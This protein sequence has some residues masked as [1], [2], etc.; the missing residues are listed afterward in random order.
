VTLTALCNHV[1]VDGSAEVAQ[2]Y[3]DR[4]SI[5][6]AQSALQFELPDSLLFA[7]IKN[8]NVNLVR[9]LAPFTAEEAVTAALESAVLGGDR[10]IVTALLEYGADPNRLSHGC[11]FRLTET[12]LQLF[13]LILRAPRPLRHEN[14]GNLCMAVIQHGDS[15][16]LNILLRSILDYQIFRD[17]TVPWNRDSLLAAA[18]S[19]PDKAAFFAITAATCSWPLR[20]NRLF[21]Q[22]LE[23]P[24]LDR[25][26]A[27]DMLEVLL[28]LI[29]SMTPT[30]Q[31]DPEMQLTL[32]HCIQQQE[33]DIL[34]L[35]VSYGVQ[36]SAEPLLL[37]CQNQDV[38]ILD[39]LLTGHIRGADQVVARISHL[40][41]YGQRDMRQRILRRLLADG[42]DG[43]WK[44]SEL[45]KAAAEGQAQWV[46]ALL[47]GNA[48]VDYHNG[49]ALLEAVSL[50]HIP[51]VQKLLSR[52]VCVGSLQAAFPSVRQLETL[53]R[54]LLTKLF[55]NQGLTGQ[56]LDE[57]LNGE[58]CNYSYHRDPDLVDMLLGAGGHC[59]DVSLTVAFE[60]RDASIFD[61]IHLSKTILHESALQWFRG[62]HRVLFR[63]IQE[64][65]EHAAVSSACLK[66]LLSK[67]DPMEGLCDTHDGTR[68]LECFHQFLERGAEDIELLSACF[69]WAQHVDSLI[70]TELVLTTACFCDLDRLQL[71]VKSKPLSSPAPPQSSSFSR[72][73]VVR[74]QPPERLNQFSAAHMPP[75]HQETLE[76]SDA[77]TAEALKVVFRQCLRDT[78]ES[79]LAT[80]LLKRHLEQ[81]T[82][83]IPRGEPWPMLAV[84]YLLSQ[85]IEVTLP[86]YNECLR[87]AITSQ[88]WLVLESMLDRQLPRD[89]LSSFLLV[90]TSSLTPAALQVLLESQAMSCMKDE[91]FSD[92]VQRAFNQACLAQDQK[93]AVL[94]CT[95]SRS[96][97]SITDVLTSLQQAIDELELEYIS[98]LL[99]ATSSSSDEL[100]VLW[101]HVTQQ[102][103][104]EFLA[105]LEILLKAGA[106]GSSVAATLL[107]AIG[108]NDE[109]LVN[110]ILAQWLAPRF[111]QHREEFDYQNC[112]P[113]WKLLN[114]VPETE[115]FTVL[116]QSL[117][118]AVRL[119]QPKICK[120]LCAA[121]APLVYQRQ[122]LIELAVVL[123][124]HKALKELIRHSTTCPEMHDAVNF[125][126][127][128][129]V[130]NNRPTWI[131]GLVELGGSVA[132][133]GLEPLKAAASLDETE[134]L[135]VLLPYNQTLDGLQA[136]H[137]ILGMRLAQPEAD[138][139]NLCAMFE[140]VH[141]AGSDCVES[142]S[143]A[144]LSLSGVRL[145][146]ADHVK[147]LIGC[148]AS[149][150]YKNGECMRQTWRHGN[151]QL[152]PLLLAQ[153]TQT[154]VV[155]GL[156]SQA[157]ED[158]LREGENVFN[159]P[160]EGALV[161]FGALLKREASQESR[162]LSLDAIARRCPIGDDCRS[163]AGGAEIVELLLENGARFIDGA[164]SPLFQVCR[165]RNKPKIQ[166]LVLKSNP[167]MRSRFSALYHLF[168]NQD[169]SAFAQSNILMVDDS[170]DQACLYN[171][172]FPASE[173][174]CIELE[175][176]DIISLL[177][178]M[179]N[180]RRRGV[181]T[182][183]MFSFFF[184]RG[185]L[186]LLAPRICGDDDRNEVEQMLVAAIM[187][188][189]RT[190]LE[191]DRAEQRIEFLLRVLQID[192]LNAAGVWSDTTGFALKEEA[193]NRL[194]ILSLQH[195]RFSLVGT[196][197]DSGADP[198][199]TDED[200][201][202]AL[203]VATVANSLD[204]M[205]IL[206]EKG[207]RENDGSLHIATC[208]QHH[209]AMHRLLEA[210]HSPSHCSPLFLDGTPLEAFL[211]CGHPGMN[212]DLFGVTLAVLLCDA[213]L[214]SDFWTREPSP[215]S[216][217]LVGSTPYE[218]FS[219]LLDLLPTKV[220]EL[221]LVRQDRFMLSIL[222]LVE[223]GDDIPLTD[224][225]R[226]DLLA[227]LEGLEFTRTYYAVEGDQPEDAVDVPEELE[228]PEIRARRRAWREKECAVCGDKP[229]DRN[230]I[231]AAL[232]PSCEDNHGW[233]D[234]I[235]CTDCLRGHLESQMFPQGND[236]FPSAKVKCWAPNCADILGHNVLQEHAETDR[237]A[238]YDAS[239]AQ[240]CLN[241][242]AN[243][244]KCANPG[245]SGAAWLDE[246]EDKDI[247]IVR[248]PVC[249][250]DTCIQ[251]NQLYDRHRDE[252]C[253]QGEEAL[254]A[255]RRREEEAAT[256]AVM[257]KGKKCP[258]CQLPYERIEGCDHIVC[259][260]DAHSQGR[261]RK[262]LTHSRPLPQTP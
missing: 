93:V 66:M 249:G 243:T 214:P 129:A 10:N 240:L 210:K 166:S 260:K 84:Q 191:R 215:L 2:I 70:F 118:I 232:S 73:L 5:D 55:I 97:L 160:A 223:R 24:G 102:Y 79:H 207:A 169:W 155:T 236:K 31:S 59:N 148:G 211:R 145:A 33:E 157:C 4:L 101:K 25:C 132:A 7:A 56:C 22:V 168:R 245:C 37:V 100:E 262:S 32:C 185:G 137:Q 61:R 227:R 130:M 128:Q 218:M 250:E 193:L 114:E 105:I 19:S 179:L 91:F 158:Y 162:D 189:E 171:I 75:L 142:F 186:R 194:L 164:G 122:S 153:C 57:A 21:L 1:H 45:V 154:S 78:C 234:S 200:G 43:V 231:H 63:H 233:D 69:R 143:N 184:M 81:C 201:R 119:D 98:T 3:I 203:Y 16:A 258:R 178:A 248:C 60:H 219:A 135:R 208:R 71:A 188:A 238:V 44:H 131:S 261:S 74:L 217:A 190:K 12:D 96:R 54:R 159:L 136:V 83:A 161:V 26:L 77:R 29:D 58:L 255:E 68:H 177:G 72:K 229:E 110:L 108:R 199:A 42:A 225:Q 196:L 107:D 115:Y 11:I 123:G 15:A 256:A 62:C 152:F 220:A 36:I 53:P 221:P 35:L 125:A 111:P 173:A 64:R 241:D 172:N 202:S 112:Q 109:R 182:T 92:V 6:A 165:L 85:P 103:F 89:M 13:Q 106:D 47:N 124:C 175:V 252:P 230:D 149:V 126:L 192:A 80:R 206:I 244:V 82:Q 205:E 30:F 50:G 39:M 259:G 65:D 216:L 86:E 224:F 23:T 187:H 183:L 163:Q 67:L 41:G 90:E 120:L 226:A 146:T 76:F 138:L 212:E 180:P 52:P 94:L 254:G 247:T 209:E 27:K 49:A 246:D 181:G 147:V 257:A 195:E 140:L 14:F 134:M 133:Y 198:N 242:G 174:E 144:L 116:A 113:I 99:G 121:G 235:I 228:A 34:R 139:D 127:L 156:L 38:R 151:V 141:I 150:E 253:P 239:L 222:S 17:G 40:Q 51:I 104:S 18:I 176:S 213:E 197:L 204:M 170:L 20:N 167:P 87:M 28:C 237:F 8:S 251:C 95:R 9:L 46:E 117:S 88:Q 48:S